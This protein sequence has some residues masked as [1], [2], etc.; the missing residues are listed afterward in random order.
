MKNSSFATI[1]T[2]NFD[3]LK[4]NEIHF[5]KLEA[6]FKWMSSEVVSAIVTWDEGGRNDQ[7]STEVVWDRYGGGP[8]GIQLR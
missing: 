3:I 8:I 6:G 1:L 2:Y 4:V 5:G 7:Y